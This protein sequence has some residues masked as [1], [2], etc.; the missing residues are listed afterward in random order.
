M[1]A[2]AWIAD[3]SRF[4]C[5]TE[6]GLQHRRELFTTATSARAALTPALAP[7]LAPDAAVDEVDN[8]SR[9]GCDGSGIEEEGDVL[10]SL[11]RDEGGEGLR[12]R[13]RRKQPSFKVSPIYICQQSAA[14]LLIIMPLEVAHF[15]PHTMNNC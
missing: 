14:A 7:L 11:R 10:S 3:G 6:L 2:L 5:S 4:I 15:Q 9:S 13:F 8:S 12:L 1:P